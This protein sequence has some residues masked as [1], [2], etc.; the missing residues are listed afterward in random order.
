MENNQNNGVPNQLTPQTPTS[1]QTPVQPPVVVQQPTPQA[2][3]QP[4]VQPATPVVP[5][6]PMTTPVTPQQSVPQVAS[7]APG[8]IAPTTPAVVPAK[9]DEKLKLTPEEEKT[10]KA[11]KAKLKKKRAIIAGIVTASIV[12]LVIIITIF[13]L[14]TQGGGSQNP[15]LRMFGIS[16]DNFYPFLIGLTNIVFGLTIFITFI[17]AIIGLF[18][19]S[20]AKKDDKSGKAKGMMMAIIGGVFFLFLAFGWTFTYMY[21]TSKLVEEQEAQDTSVIATVP[22][23]LTGLTAPMTIEFDASGVPYNSYKYEIISYEW[24]FG[25]GATATGV[26]TSHKYTEKGP[27][28]GR[29]EVTLTMT[30]ADINT[31]EEG[32][33]SIVLDVVFANEKVSAVFSADPVEGE[34][35]LEVEFDAS[36]S[37]DP[38][39]EIVAYEW[40]LD[41]DGDYDDAE[42]VS[43]TYTYEQTGIYTAGL[44]V[45]DNN[46]EY[47]TYEVEINA[48]SAMV[49]MAV[50]TETN[51]GEYYAGTEYSFSASSSSSPNGEIEKYSWDF[52]DESRAVTTRSADHTYEE[53]GTYVIKLMIT[54]ETDET[55]TETIQIEVVEPSQKP[56]AVITTVPTVS[57][58]EGAIVGD[59]PFTVAFSASES[60]DADDNI[61]DYEWDFDG[62]GNADDTGETTTYT[63]EEVGTYT[64]ELK[65]IDAD[66]N[67]DTATVVISAEAQGLTATLSASPVSGE[68]PLEVE[69]SAAGSSYPEG[70]IV[71]YSWDFGDGTS[72][73][74]SGAEVTYEYD[75]IGSFTATVMVIASDGSEDISTMNIVVRPVT[76]SACFEPS[77]STGTAPLIVTFDSNCSTGSVQSY[78]WDFGDGNKNYDRKPTHTFNSV[79]VYTVELKVEDLDGVSDTYE[80]EIIVSD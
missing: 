5:V 10:L 22:E 26:K 31:G 44:R 17:V 61:V 56:I 27:D 63:Y 45:T 4:I 67:E 75:E 33:E 16:E 3:V 49:P 46:G 77:M 6:Q 66:G 55:G 19:A 50:I 39:G 79:G 74:V 21:L 73:Y 24:D 35:P 69:F 14:L 30:Y 25:D 28:A 38:D 53:T 62:D 48:T 18:K 23:E 76:I 43:A 40:D 80:M 1:Q 57:E 71:A 7:V 8:A 2:P 29:Y 32:E 51:E 70:E 11:K 59:I 68:V 54:D 12:F 72:E 52:G 64:A 47:G 65:V 41:G 60:T 36:E 13:L 37:S 78:A 42:G 58:D 34:I 9:K 15:L 20:M